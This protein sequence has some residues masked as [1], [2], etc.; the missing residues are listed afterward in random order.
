MYLV[1]ENPAAQAAAAAAAAL[2][3]AGSN[4]RACDR[5]RKQLVAKQ[6]PQQQGAFINHD[7]FDCIA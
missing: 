3:G 6:Q 1:V 5:K 4:W 2:E 7:P